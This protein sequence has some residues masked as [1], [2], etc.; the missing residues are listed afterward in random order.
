MRPVMADFTPGPWEYVPSTD[1]H[2]PYV[3]SEFGSTI[4]DL[5]TMSHPKEWSTANGGPSKPIPFL[6]EMADPNA[7]LIAAAPN[8]LEAL[9]ELSDLMD[10]VMN[11][12][13]KPDSFTLQ[14]ARAAIAKATGQGSGA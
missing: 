1:H 4:C 6:A 5:Y 11:G 2:G 14:P 10:G 8:L 3:T 13:Y 7:R 9:T 12:S